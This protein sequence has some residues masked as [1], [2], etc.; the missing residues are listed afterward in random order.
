MQNAASRVR[1][2]PLGFLPLGIIP[3]YLKGRD[4]Q[5]LGDSETLGAFPLSKS[6]CL[7]SLSKLNRSFWNFKKGG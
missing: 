1:V 4:T 3:H 2:L 5:L 7:N 6:S